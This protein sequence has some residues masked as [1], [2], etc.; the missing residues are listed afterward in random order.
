MPY[1]AREIKEETLLKDKN[2]LSEALEAQEDKCLEGGNGG[3]KYNVGFINGKSTVV[4]L[5]PQLNTATGKREA[6]YKI[7]DKEVKKEDIIKL[8]EKNSEDKH[9]N[10]FD[11]LLQAI[12][13][14]E[15]AKDE[16]EK[17][18]TEKTSHTKS[19]KNNISFDER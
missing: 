12:N 17:E 3:F 10:M 11:S 14:G 15:K 13:K 7:N 1:N 9:H 19:A 2:A 4:S 6:V 5:R 16:F 18:K 8:C